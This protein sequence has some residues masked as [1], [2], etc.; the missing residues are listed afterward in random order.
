M[1]KKVVLSGGTGFVGVYLTYLL[2]KKGYEVLVLTRTPRPNTDDVSYFAWDVAAGRI[3]EKAILEADYI[4]H[5]A[6]E[7]IGDKRWT[8]ARKKAILDSRVQSAALISTVLRSNNHKVKAFISASGV[9]IYGALNGKGICTEETQ[10]A[11]DFLG[12]VCVEWEKAADAFTALGIRTVKIRTGLVLGPNAGIL[13]KMLPIFKKGL[14]SALGSGKQFMPWIHIHD[15]CAIY[16]EAIE[17]EEMRGAYNATIEDSTT[18]TIFT[19]V[20]ANIYN[21]SVWLPN[22]PAFILELFLGEMAVLV[23]T[24]RRVSN[25]K[26]LHLGFRFQFKSLDD[27]LRNC[28][29][30]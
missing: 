20:L 2:V 6:G 4:I 14:G 16:L 26:L 23:L 25:N 10:V 19:K 22:V 12:K 7:S 1:K 24:G 27:A 13:Q 17:N 28:L 21:Y 18:N 29:K 3:N 5:L 8:V 9:G 11:H 15:L 30:K